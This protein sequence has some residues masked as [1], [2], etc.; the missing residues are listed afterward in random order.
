LYVAYDLEFQIFKVCVEIDY[1]KCNF[2]CEAKQ[3]SNYSGGKEFI[4]E[5]WPI[6]PLELLSGDK[7]NMGRAIC[8]SPSF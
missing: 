5:F 1:H 3:V 7:K 6:E 8:K 4:V 2:R